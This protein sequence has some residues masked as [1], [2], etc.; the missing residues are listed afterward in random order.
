VLVL[1]GTLDKLVKPDDTWKIFTNLTTE[2]RMLIAL[3]SEHLVLEYGS[4]KSP[5]YD[6][7]TAELVANWMRNAIMP[8]AEYDDVA[9]H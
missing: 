5:V 8:A 1:Q 7:K 6:A 2:C 9:S 4:V 3:R